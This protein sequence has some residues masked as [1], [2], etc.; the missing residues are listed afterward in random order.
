MTVKMNHGSEDEMSFFDLQ[1]EVEGW[2]CE[3]PVDRKTKKR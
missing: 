1:N 2:S 3:I